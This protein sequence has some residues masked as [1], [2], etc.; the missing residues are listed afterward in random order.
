ME[1]V[2]IMKKIH[3]LVITISVILFFLSGCAGGVTT[4][5]NDEIKVKNSINEY[6]LALNDQN[7]SKAKSYC[8]FGSEQYN[9]TTQLENTVKNYCFSYDDCRVVIAMN[10]TI[11]DTWF[12]GPYFC[13]VYCNMNDFSAFDGDYLNNTQSYIIYYHLEKVGN[14]WK[15]FEKHT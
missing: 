13:C 11:L 8:T 9:D 5:S 15:L 7:W 2:I 1:E 6:F 4:P 3:F 12:N 10:P 14:E